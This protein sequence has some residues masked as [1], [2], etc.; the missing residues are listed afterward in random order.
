MRW[1]V[2]VR[3]GADLVL[4]QEKP[5]SGASNDPATVPDAHDLAVSMFEGFTEGHVVLEIT[6]TGGNTASHT[7]VFFLP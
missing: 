2:L 6:D 3:S 7:E 5:G 1:E 4:F